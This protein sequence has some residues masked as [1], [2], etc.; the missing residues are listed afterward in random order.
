MKGFF[1]VLERELVERRLLALV[2]LIVGLLPLAVPWVSR[3]RHLDPADI[4]SGAALAFCMTFTVVVAI[5][6]GASVIAGDLA[7]RRLGFYFS[8][9]LSGWALWGGKIVATML[10][11]L[12][13]GFLVLLPTLLSGG[14][15]MQGAWPGRALRSDLLSLGAFWMT[16]TLFL[17]VAS[18]AASVMIRTRSPWLA[19][20]LAAASVVGLLLWSA[21]FE[22][23]F[24]GAVPF[25]SFWDVLAVVLI[26][27]GFAIAGAAQVL[28]GRTDPRRGHRVLS[29]TLW[30]LLLT[31]AAA[32]QGLARWMLDVSPEDLALVT[33]VHS[34]PSGP[35]VAL[36]GPARHRGE[37]RPRFLLDTASG[38]YV[39]RRGSEPLF[40]ADGAR[41]VWLEP[42]GRSLRSQELV[43]YRL[44]LRSPDSTPVRTTISFDGYPDTLALSPRGDRLAS[45]REDR[46]L[47]EDPDRGK[48]L[49]SIQ[50]PRLARALWREGAIQ[51]LD[52]G[53]I[54][55]LQVL[56]LEGGSALFDGGF[57]I[58]GG[59]IDLSREK[60]FTPRRIV[61]GQGYPSWSV[62]PDGSRILLHRGFSWT[63]LDLRTGREIA[64]LTP[65]QGA[66]P[67]FLADGRIAA[68]ASRKELRIYSPDLVLERSF[69]FN[70]TLAAETGGQPAPGQ[71]I[72]A[73]SQLDPAI[74]RVPS[75]WRILLLD[76]AT[77]K[78]RS[79]APR[80][81]PSGSLKRGPQSIGSR[82][83]RDEYGGLV[84]LDPATGKTRILVRGS[85][86][87]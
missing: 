22:L 33:E 83:F 10:L 87:S 59:V 4:R 49:A 55:F 78:A 45:S 31:L 5:L 28:H 3:A 74:S 60:S 75:S 77:G 81:L 82:L 54:L 40:S 7:E 38:R 6:L 36:S 73:V 34:A 23:L 24:V 43:L 63:L 69:R 12:G 8:R 26:F 29:L 2:A 35:W 71:L 27:S 56:P 85:R 67:E 30:G 19:V 39:R 84:V 42:A 18:H 15:D 1:A 70:R 64:A 80:L 17:I 57:E 32:G 58:V 79:L 25:P 68:R 37:Y 46:L 62:S 51:F 20:D 65:E 9:P 66:S 76:L 53:H 48:I 61:T 14:I 41:V 47:L 13:G 11:T 50:L 86:P 16:G 52:S 21:R 72:V 44:D